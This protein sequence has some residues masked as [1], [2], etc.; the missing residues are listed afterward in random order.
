MV[1]LLRLAVNSF[2]YQQHESILL[3][4]SCSEILEIFAA[5][6]FTIRFFERSLR[7][8]SWFRWLIIFKVSIEIYSNVDIC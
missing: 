3:I 2:M 7:S 6:E 1:N 8:S 5:K 4:F